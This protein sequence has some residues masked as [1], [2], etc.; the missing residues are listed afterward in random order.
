MTRWFKFVL[1]KMNKTWKIINMIDYLWGDLVQLHEVYQKHVKCSNYIFEVEHWVVV[2]SL[3]PYSI[4]EF[5]FQCCSCINWFS[6]KGGILAFCL[7]SFSV[8]P[9]RHWAEFSRYVSEGHSLIERLA[10][11]N[12]VSGLLIVWCLVIS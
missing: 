8:I 5:N 4:L 6:I 12:K 9:Q 7:W 3:D 10:D 2:G 11:F 1:G